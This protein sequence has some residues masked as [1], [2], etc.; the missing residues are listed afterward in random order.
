MDENDFKYVLQDLTNVYLGGQYSYQEM[1]EEDSVP[2]KLKTIFA[3]Y[4]MKEV[5]GET[6]LS[7]HIFYLEKD[8]LSCLAYRQLKARFRLSVWEEADGKKRKQAGYVSR[9]Y[10][11]DEILADQKLR[12]LR[13]STIVEELH[14]KKVQILAFS[15]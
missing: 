10:T 9:E 1:M 14:L 4:M 5:A 6:R 2:F 11:I 7:D 8:S 3:R 13:D 12:A 15:G